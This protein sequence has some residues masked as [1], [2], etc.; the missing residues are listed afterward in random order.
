MLEN[1]AAQEVSLY[2]HRNNI[3]KIKLGHVLCFTIVQAVL[4]KVLNGMLVASDQNCVSMMV[5][6]DLGATF[7]IIVS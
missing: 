7:D 1:I 3:Q 5:L 2:L 4:V 6:I